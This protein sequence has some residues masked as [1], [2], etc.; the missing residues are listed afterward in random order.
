MR[1]AS[2]VA[3]WQMDVAEPDGTP[4]RHQPAVRV[5][6]RA[7]MTR[8][9]TEAE[10]WFQFCALWLIIVADMYGCAWSRVSAGHPGRGVT[11]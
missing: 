11:R 1:R 2:A 3:A 6:A 5:E 10:F 8:P 4:Q 7:P 9:L